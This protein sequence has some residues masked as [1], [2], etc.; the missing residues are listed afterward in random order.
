[1]KKGSVLKF[2]RPVDADEGHIRMILLEDPDGGRVLVRDLL[3]MPL[4]PT[5]VYPVDSLEVVENGN[6]SAS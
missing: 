1:M 5:H 4:P 6:A 3:D 2:K